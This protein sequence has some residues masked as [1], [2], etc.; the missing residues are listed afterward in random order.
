M[1]NL[2]KKKHPGPVVT[3]R[4]CINTPAKMNTMLAE[5]KS[6]QNIAF[7]FWFDDSL[8]QANNFFSSHTNELVTLLTN[9]EAT[10]AGLQGKTPMFAEHYPLFSKEIALFQKL[11]LKKALV[12]SSLDEPLF[13]NVGGEKIISL[14]KKMGMKDDEVIEHSMISRSI[15]NV[16]KKIA[17]KVVVEQSACSQQDWF[18]KNLTS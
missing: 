7:I 3:D 15:Q 5:W 9:R 1:F 13:L 8:Q 16:Q 6:N 2:F 17:E 12:L 10:I 14:M 18:Q 11:D 4:V